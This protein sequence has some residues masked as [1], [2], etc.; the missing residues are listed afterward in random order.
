MFGDGLEVIWELQSS[1]FSQGVGY[2]SEIKRFGIYRISKI[3]HKR[4]NRLSVLTGVADAEEDANEDVEL[5][6]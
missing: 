5:L 4:P 3:G 1:R 6:I 2:F